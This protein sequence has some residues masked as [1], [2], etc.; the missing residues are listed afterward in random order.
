[1]QT[2]SST[3]RDIDRLNF[4]IQVLEEKINRIEGVSK[5]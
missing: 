5:K 4:K 3:Q 1:M 2:Y